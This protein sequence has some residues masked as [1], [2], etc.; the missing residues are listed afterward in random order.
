MIRCSALPVAGGQYSWVAVLAPKSIARGMSY[1]S[2]WFM[3]IGILAMGA[4]NNFI[5][6]NFVLGMA[7]LTNPEYAIQRW[8]TVLVTYLIAI[9]AMLSNIFL[10]RILNNLSRFI[11][12]WNIVSF[13]VVIITVVACN[14]NKQSASFVFSDF[15]NFTGFGNSYAAVLGIVQSAFGM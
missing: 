5:A 10:A 15:Q 11:L 6:A 7:N 8:H 14:D 12:L 1:V 2:G 13:F 4:V 9:V 3:L